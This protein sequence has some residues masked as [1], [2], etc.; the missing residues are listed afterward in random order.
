VSDARSARPAPRAMSGSGPAALREVLALRRAGGG[1]GGR[2]LDC[3]AGEGWLA[4]RLAEAGFD[5]ACA[6]IDPELARS[7]GLECARVDLNRD[8]LP[9]EAGSFECVA[10]VGGLH[11]LYSVRHALDEFHRVLAPGG[12]LVVGAVNHGS[13]VRRLRFFFTGSMGKRLSR[14]PSGAAPG[15]PDAPEASFR[16]ALTCGE[17][18]AAL[19]AA[20]FCVRSVR[21]TRVSLRA[22]LLLPLG[23]LVWLTG[24]LWGGGHERLST[25]LGGRHAVLVAE[26]TAEK[27]AEKT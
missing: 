10:C 8:E 23:L 17:I 11:R 16:T 25:V 27:P 4:A 9:F 6:D 21:A 2:V 5:V 14:L 26:K 18:A 3:P 20:G 1:G 15:A 12:T 19:E 24:K 22:A 7:H 13:L